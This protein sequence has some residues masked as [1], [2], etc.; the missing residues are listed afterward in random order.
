MATTQKAGTMATIDATI[1][2]IEEKLKQ[3]KA[4]KQKMDAAKRAAE[5]KVV[6]ANDTR[7]KILLGAFMLNNYSDIL[8]LRIGE[9]R[10]DDS[11]IRPDDRAIFGLDPLPKTDVATQ[12]EQAV[13]L[14]NSPTVL[15]VPFDD[16]NEAKAL[17]A[18]WSVDKRTWSVPAGLDLTPFKKWIR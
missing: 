5:T 14:S 16:K 6:R 17:G 10:F 9:K 11:L 12:P 18:I 7:K 13:P 3:A 4:K 1:K 8:N 15:N 2:A